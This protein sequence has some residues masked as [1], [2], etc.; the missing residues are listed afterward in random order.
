MSPAYAIKT[1]RELSPLKIEAY[2]F[3]LTEKDAAKKSSLATLS[4][5]IT[6]KF[7][8]DDILVFVAQISKA[9][10]AEIRK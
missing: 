4:A 9:K 8:R 1:L 5:A 3:S 6:K 7:T 2:L 10:A